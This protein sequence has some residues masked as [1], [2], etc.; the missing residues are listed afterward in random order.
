MNSRQDTETQPLVDVAYVVPRSIVRELKWLATAA[1]PIVGSFY[2]HYAFGFINMV[3][4]GTW[5]GSALGAYA[6][7]NM[8]CAILAFAPATGVASALDT[9]CAASFTH[10]G[11]GRQVGL[12]LQRGL[13]AVTM[14]YV[15]VF[16]VV[17]LYIPSIYAFLGQA[18]ELALPAASYLRVLSLG[19]WPWMAFECLKRYIQAN[20]QMRLPAMVLL[21]VVPLH[22]LNHWVFVWQ[23]PDASFT[24]VAWITVISYW[25]MFLGLAACTLFWD[26]LRPAWH[27]HRVKA[28]VS[29]SFYSLAAPAMVEACG[30]YMAF[31]IMTLFATYLGPTSLAAQAIAFSSMSMFYQLPHGVGAAA[32]VR[33]GRLLG[34][35][36]SAGAKFSAMVLV[37]GGL[38]YSTVGS[39]FFAF[40]GSWW[41]G[42]YTKDAEVLAIASK[43]V[44]IAAAIE[45]T[46]AS[47]GIVPGILRGMGKQRKAATINVASY[48]FVVLPLGIIA[49][50]VLDKGILGL[51][52]AFAV[53][54]ISEA[55]RT[56]PRMQWLRSRPLDKPSD[57]NLGDTTDSQSYAEARDADAP[58]Q[59][60]PPA[61]DDYDAKGSADIKP[62]DAKTAE[63]KTAETKPADDKSADDKSADDKS[64]DDKSAESMDVGTDKA[65][66]PAPLAEPANDDDDAA[67]RDQ[68]M[69][70]A[71]SPA[72]GR[73][74]EPSAEIRRKGSPQSAAAAAA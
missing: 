72:L 47:R 18:D 1:T 36:D 48:Y 41:V 44:L 28:L 43:L 66:T 15:V 53:G 32:A 21:A 46:D 27:P 3:S 69:L 17:Q 14:W 71:K 24:A 57:D 5:G 20:T 63:T 49:V 68:P 34:E 26:A 11:G 39:L 25:L 65:S 12:H 56:G 37:I 9:L 42:T 61:N 54:I 29:T 59:Q 35:R 10:F 16:A 70:P 33:I 23:Q 62:V 6:L 51:W 67:T 52:T 74:S 50:F 40:C 60:E 4:L 30:E 8:T 31:E 19:L 45:W 55:S 73:A 64:A 38:L 2:L 22:L 7:A 58:A 13:L